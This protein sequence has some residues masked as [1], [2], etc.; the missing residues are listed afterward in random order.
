MAGSVGIEPTHF[1]SK[2]NICSNRFT[3]NIFTHFHYSYLFILTLV[4]LGRIELPTHR[5][6][7]CC[8]TNWATNPL[9]L[10]LSV[11]IEP[12]SCGLQPHAMTT[13]AKTAKFFFILYFLSFTLNLA[14]SVGIEPTHFG[15]KP[16]ICSNRFT[17]NIFLLFSLQGLQ[18][19]N[20]N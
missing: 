19:S 11:G 20:L 16:N 7:V 13:S 2:P 18:D 1:G 3:P 17:P 12:T 10:V 15:S 6:S 4:D 14:G 8:S 5:F 9:I